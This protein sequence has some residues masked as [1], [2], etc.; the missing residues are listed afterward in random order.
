MKLLINERSGLY[1]KDHDLENLAAGIKERMLELGMQSPL[2]YY[3]HF[4]SSAEI[5]SEIRELLNILT[6]NEFSE[7]SE[8]FLTKNIKSCKMNT[9]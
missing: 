6:I 3:D 4:K 5:E 2:S 7:F 9:N 8:F 1:F